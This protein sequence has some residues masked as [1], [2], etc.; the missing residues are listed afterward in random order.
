M[1]VRIYYHDTDC[2]GVVYYA[3]YLKYLEEARSE[4]F[5]DRGLI[6]KDL[7][8]EGIGFVVARQE[9]DYKSPSFYGDILEVKAR[10]TEAS[11]TKVN[12]EYAIVNQNGRLIA[13]A[14]TVL[15][16]VDKDLKP[17]RI[18]EDILKKLR[19]NKWKIKRK[20]TQG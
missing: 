19:D 13:A 14:K 17:K 20:D 15:V 4:Y 6:I 16:F 18:P 12:F 1:L 9:I 11:F 2:G 8:N 5:E 3:N 10:I 7:R